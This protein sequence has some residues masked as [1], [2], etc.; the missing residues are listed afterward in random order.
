MGE[1]CLLGAIIGGIVDS[2]YE[3]PDIRTKDFPLFGTGCRMTDNSNL[4]LA[5]NAKEISH[6][7]RQG[8]QDKYLGKTGGRQPRISLIFC[9]MASAIRR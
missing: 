5:G 7:R 8:H 1:E 2:I 6:R 9:S 4:T 3:F